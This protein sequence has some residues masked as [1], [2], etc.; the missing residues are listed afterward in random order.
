[1][2]LFFF[3]WRQEARVAR[4][5]ERLN[6]LAPQYFYSELAARSH[7]LLYSAKAPQLANG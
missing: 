7:G 2:H 3:G 5:V 6:N 4:V 1:M